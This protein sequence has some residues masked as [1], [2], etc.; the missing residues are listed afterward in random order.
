[1]NEQA[2]Q[3]IEPEE[4]AELVTYQPP[5]PPS[6]FGTDD[7]VEV[8]AR[9]SR[10]AASLKEV[11]KA[12]GLIS[13]I[14]GK[15]YPRCEAWTLLGT[16]LGVFP[17]LV[18][19]RP[20]EGGWEARVEARTR[21]G[22]VVGA[23]EAQCLKTER[24]W[25]DRDDFALRSMAQTRATAKALR[26]PL[27][28]VM[29]LGGFQ[30]TPA[31][32]MDFEQKQPLQR[33]QPANVSRRT[34]ELERTINE[35]MQVRQRGQSW[36]TD[37]SSVP[38]SLHDAM[39]EFASKQYESRAVLQSE[40]SKLCK[41]IEEFGQNP[42]EALRTVRQCLIGN[43]P[44]RLQ[45][46]RGG[47]VAVQTASSSVAQTVATE[48]QRQRWISA[49]R[50]RGEYGLGYCYDKGWLLPDSGPPDDITPGEPIEMLEARHVPTTR[51]AADAI[52]AELDGLMPAD[53]RPK[54][55]GASRPPSESRGQASGASQGN[56]ATKKA[57]FEPTHHSE[58]WYQWKM[59]FGKDKGRMLGELDKKT[60]WGWW[61]NYEVETHWNGKPKKPETIANDERF[62]EM[63]D[64]AGA[65]YKFEEPN[66]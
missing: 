8:V 33:Q 19:S 5:Q 48:E 22:A 50:D 52:L 31:E 40:V 54:P 17:V 20:V 15:E 14:S 38:P 12:Q 26:M 39:E 37:L 61:C 4:H 10:V 43:A 27:G 55:A 46:A 32:E 51:K 59:A 64:Q 18:W 21:D 28:F 58:D 36:T 23:A 63:L 45:Q 35:L 41:T 56:V 3:K 29:T 47:N 13:K 60:L 7:P 57:G 1:M 42:E 11:I 24:N 66:D 44:S 65:F 9:A 53:Q 30:A 6:L 2:L 16:M 62:R 49:L 34:N 25:R